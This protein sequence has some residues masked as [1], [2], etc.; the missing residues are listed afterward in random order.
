MELT[1]SKSVIEQKA[2][3]SSLY[4]ILLGDVGYRDLSLNL[5]EA[6]FLP[7]IYWPSDTSPTA[8]PATRTLDMLL[9]L[10]ATV[11]G[12]DA[13]MDRHQGEEREAE[14]WVHFRRREYPHVDL[15]TKHGV[16]LVK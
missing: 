16:M 9:D 7:R 13:H 14:L 5:G 12:N 11:L 6:A 15:V 8:I 4:S 2:S 3:L 1:R 10:Q